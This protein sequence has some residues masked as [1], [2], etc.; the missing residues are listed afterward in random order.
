RHGMAVRFPEAKVRA[1]GRNARGVRG[2]SL[3][4]NDRVISAQWVDSSQVILTTTANGYGKLTKVDEYRR[5]NRGGKGVIAI[6]TNERNGD[7]VG[8]LAVTERDELM[9]VSDHGTLIRI[10]VNSIRRTGRN[11]QGVRLINLGEGEQLAGL[12]LIA[13]TDEEEGEQT[14]LPQ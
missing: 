9:L 11:A 6:Q 12:A 14:D 8:A 1:M 5:T 3:E 10:A 4:E 2:I 13:D 7:V